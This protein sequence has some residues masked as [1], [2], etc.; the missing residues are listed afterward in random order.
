MR[1]AR[2]WRQSA[3]DAT[4]GGGSGNVIPKEIAQN[5]YAKLGTKK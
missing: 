2:T 5:Q 4:G 3:A 1:G